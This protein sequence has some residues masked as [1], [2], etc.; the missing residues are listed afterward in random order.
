MLLRLFRVRTA[1][2]VRT[3]YWPHE[4]VNR[5]VLDDQLLGQFHSYGGSG[6]HIAQDRREAECEMELMKTEKCSKYSEN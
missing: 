3:K 1:D 4:L 2:E 6:H 5:K